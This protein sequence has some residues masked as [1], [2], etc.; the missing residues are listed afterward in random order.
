[1]HTVLSV[2]CNLGTGVLYVEAIHALLK[3]G[4]TIAAV[5]HLLLLYDYW[6]SFFPPVVL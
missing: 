5:K 3:V 4:H 2:L 6:A 1:M